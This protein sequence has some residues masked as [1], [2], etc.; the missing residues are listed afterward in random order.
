MRILKAGLGFLFFSVVW[1]FINVW[2]VQKEERKTHLT[3]R[4]KDGAGGTEEEFA[5]MIEEKMDV[6]ARMKAPSVCA[7][8]QQSPSIGINAYLHILQTE[9]VSR[10]GFGH[11]SDDD[12]IPLIK[13]NFWSFSNLPL[14]STQT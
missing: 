7:R 11:S 14:G 13:I 5:A 6:M 3:A 8:M 10:L 9:C 12:C 4:V 2:V 1:D